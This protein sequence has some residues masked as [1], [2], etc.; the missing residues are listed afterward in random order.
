MEIRNIKD[1]ELKDALNLVWDVFLKFEAPDYTEEGINEFKNSINNPDFIG[2]MELFGAYEKDELIGVIATREKHHLS[3]LFVREDYHRKGIG[4]SLYEYICKLNPDGYFTVNSSPY[5]KGFY[6]KLGFTCDSSE[7]IINGIRFYPMKNENINIDRFRHEI[8]TL[9]RKDDAIEYIKEFL[10]YGSDI[11]GVGSLDKYLDNY[12]EW[13]EK[14]E[15]YRNIEPNEQRVPGDTYFLVREN[16]NR[17]VGMINI[18][19]CLNDNLRLIGGHIGYSIRP[20]ERQKG[21]NKIN[22]YLGLLR[23]QELGIKEVLMDCD[24]DNP[25]SARTMIAL[26]GK[27][28]KEWYEPNIYKTILQDYA[29]DVDDSIKTYAKTYNPRIWK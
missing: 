21:Y 10:E 16:D 15:T 27:L 6:E 3:L 4:K 29:I 8:P 20:T 26:G 14:L 19:H 28:I 24:K 5:A 22:L 13:L 23:C 2:K 25:A 1:S 18:R 7:Q 17:I 12:E 9:E 11:N